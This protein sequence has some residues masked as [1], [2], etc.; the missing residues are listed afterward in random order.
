M[1]SEPDEVS[2]AKVVDGSGRL[3]VGVNRTDDV[4]EDEE[5]IRL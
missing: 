2:Y 3:L 5:L 1:I 4:K